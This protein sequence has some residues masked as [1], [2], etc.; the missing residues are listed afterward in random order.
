MRGGK[1][2]IY[3]VG[4]GK[5]GRKT[6]RKYRYVLKCIAKTTIW[7]MEDIKQLITVKLLRQ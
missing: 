1:R 6:I 3:V 5:I 2:K 4:V 7:A